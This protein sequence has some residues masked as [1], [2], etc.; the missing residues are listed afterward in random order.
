LRW[1]KSV[2]GP[3][4]DQDAGVTLANDGSVVI[5]GSFSGTSSFGEGP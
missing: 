5:S 1:A 2:G 4:Y 3:N